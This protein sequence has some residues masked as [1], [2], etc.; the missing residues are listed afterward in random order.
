MSGISG[1][2]ELNYYSHCSSSF[3]LE[4]SKIKSIVTSNTTP[5]SDQQFM[6]KLILRNC[7]NLQS[8]QFLHDNGMEEL[9]CSGNPLLSELYYSGHD[10]SLKKVEVSDCPKL[11]TISIQVADLGALSFSK[12]PSLN[13]LICTDCCLTG[14]DLTNVY[15]VRYLNCTNNPELQY[16]YC[17]IRPQYVYYDLG[18]TTIV[19]ID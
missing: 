19:V 9:I 11:S 1:A 17:K 13:R 18:S 3:I 10:W 2:F 6:K 8:V 12:L 5:V 7:P 4:N 14:L 15:T 16:V